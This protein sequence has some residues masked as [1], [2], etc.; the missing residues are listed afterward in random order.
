MKS[1]L[2]MILLSLFFVSSPALANEDEGGGLIK[3]KPIYVSMLPHFLVNLAD[4]KGQKFMQIKAN[5][6]V[7]NSDTEA[8]LKL[9]M[10]A[11]RHEILMILSHLAPE[12]VRT[13]DQKEALRENVTE[14]IRVTLRE[15]AGYD[16]VKGFYMTSIVVQ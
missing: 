2:F 13:S 16:D 6:L 3:K 7:A 5:T 12:D 14:S 15:L 9:H 4:A 1:R 11:V 8:A 10:P